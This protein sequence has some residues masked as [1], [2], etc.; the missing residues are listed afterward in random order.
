MIDALYKPL[1]NG[2]DDGIIR[3]LSQANII[4]ACS[5]NDVYVFKYPSLGLWCLNI[6]VGIL[7]HISRYHFVYL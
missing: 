7:Y 1:A 4:C 6:D 2:K 5:M 3:Y